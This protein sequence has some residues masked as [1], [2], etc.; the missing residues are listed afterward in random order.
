MRLGIALLAA[1]RLT[2]H[3]VSI[4]TGEIKVDGARA[5]YE[6][7]MPLYEVSHMTDPAKALMEAVRFKTGGAEGKRLEGG[8][9]K[10]EAESAWICESVY[11]F[12]APVD[13]L[14]ATSALHQVTVPN[15]VHMLRAVREGFT[16][17]AVLDISFPTAQIRFR[18]PGLAEK[19]G[20]QTSAGALRAAG[21]AAQWLF[22]LALVLAA[23]SRSELLK[24]TGMFLLGEAI[25]CVVLPM[26]AWQPAPRFVEAAAALTIAY[27]A[28]EVLL[29]PGAGQRWLVVAVLGVFHGLYFALFVQS[30]GF[31]EG[32]VLLGVAAAEIVLIA[33]VAAVLSRIAR[34]VPAVVPAR[35]AP[36]LLMVV[37]LGWFFA[38]IA[39]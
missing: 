14:E 4:S 9:R 11:E 23:R 26:T 17:Q 7:R 19:I 33:A 32:W 25:A 13:S 35:V 30:S 36:A 1:M 16:D 8:C 39:S 5:R 21:G 2:A 27:L 22:V 3:M 15:H 18:P 28:V 29:L 10:V 24:L 37:G 34:V 31:S 6:I 38:R 12:S 20:Q